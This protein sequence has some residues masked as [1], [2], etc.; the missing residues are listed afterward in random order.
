[1]HSSCNVNLFKVSRL[2]R[3]N[4]GVP[5]G[6]HISCRQARFV[7]QSLTTHEPMRP[8]ATMSTLF[9]GIRLPHCIYFYFHKVTSQESFLAHVHSSCGAFPRQT[10]LSL[11]TTSPENV[12]CDFTLPEPA[13]EIRH[14]QGSTST[15]QQALHAAADVVHRFV[16][17]QI[18]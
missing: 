12:A 7:Y 5:A 15:F 8:Q 14:A 13:E 3:L 4:C 11:R 10:H 6:G 2:Q 9:F 1:M 18:L 16:L 17:G